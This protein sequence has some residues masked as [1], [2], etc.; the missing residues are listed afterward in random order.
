VK[1]HVVVSLSHPTARVWGFQATARVASTPA[2]NAGAFA[3]V[4]ATTSVLC[5]ASA[6]DLSGQRFGFGQT[7]GC[8][9]G[10][11]LA[12]IEHASAR[13]IAQTF[14]FDWTPPAANVGD[15]RFFFAVNAANGN[16]NAEGDD[17]LTTTATLSPGATG[18]PAIEFNGIQNGAS[19]EPGIVPNSWISIKGAN[20]STTTN[21]WDKAIVDGK[22]PTELDGVTVSVGGRPAYIYYVSPTQ[23]NVL[24]PDV[25]IGSLPVS[26]RN[27][28][29][30][31]TAASAMSN[32]FMP[33]FFLWPGKQAVAT[34]HPDGGY[35]VKNGTF[36][37]TTTTPAKPGDVI[38][39]WGTGFGPTTPA[40]PVGSVTLPGV[41]YDVVN[42]VTVTVGGIPAEVIGAAL[43]SGF[44]GLYQIAIVVPA[45]APNG[46]LAVVATVSGAQSPAGVT[47]SVQR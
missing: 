37:G 26:V 16:G 12:L 9:A 44:V 15:V 17:T 7:Q 30:T 39:L 10:K 29:G 18:V 31:S 32:R 2:T 46:D 19:F 43:S 40:A 3:S 35:A 11:P 24:A 27:S 20:L 4:D 1:Q 41:R 6:T 8:P 21:T 14:E 23:V 45:G 38:V 25:G 42:P 5:A 47:L 34:R 36:P 33:A 22:L 13:T 28:L